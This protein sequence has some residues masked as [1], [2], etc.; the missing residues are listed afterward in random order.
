MEYGLVFT[1]YSTIFLVMLIITF[2]S[3]RNNKTIRVKLYTLAMICAFLF[4]LFELLTIY[5][6]KYITPSDFIAMF[7]W[8][9]RITFVIAFFYVYFSYCVML[10]SKKEYSSVKETIFKT[11]ALQIGLVVTFIAFLLAVVILKSEP[12]VLK[13]FTYIGGIIGKVLFTIAFLL[14]AY[15]I[16][17]SILVFKE[18]KYYLK[19]FIIISFIVLSLMLLQISQPTISYTPTIVI[20][21]V[22]IIYFN[23]ENPDIE[24]SENI[25]EL[26]SSVENLGISKI[27]FLFNISYDLVHPANTI[28]SLSET[29]SHK[30]EFN[31]E[32]ILK[33]LNNI[34]YEGALML[35]SVNN[36][37]DV[38]MSNEE[39]HNNEYKLNDLIEK[40]Q[41]DIKIKIDKKPIKFSIQ[42][43]DIVSASLIGD[44]DKVEKILF[45]VLNNAV[46]YTE[47][48]N[49][50]F[51]VS[52]TNDKDIQNVKFEISDTGIG[53]KDEIKETIFN[54][55]ISTDNKNLSIGL[56]LTK[57]LVDELGGTI[58]FNSTYKVGTT[59]YITI[60]QKVS[61]NKTY[62]HEQNENEHRNIEG[63]IDCSNYKLLVV[64]DDMLDIKVTQRLLE[65][66]NFQITTINSPLEC[67]DRIK[68]DEKYDMLL[69]DHKM[70]EMDGIEL[71]KILRD[72]QATKEVKYVMLT[73]NAVAGMKE[74]CI[75]E[76]FDEYIS[77]PINLKELDKIIKKYF[78]K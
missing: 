58:T 73:A 78:K 7:N 25:R 60:P 6:K 20:I 31:K 54:D 77:K 27:D 17:S 33:D 47:V 36:I 69:I 15:T 55:S 21:I 65:K 35:D 74:Y 2:T 37:V 61:G 18:K 23:I 70:P 52:A 13:D 75:K 71:M 3:K 26:K 24:L 59:F 67:I 64:D 68:A 29:L 30:Q 8:K 12:I 39:V 10:F 50:K 11:K 43:D 72:L 9:V 49:I 32:E 48:G 28:L 1:M 40:I 63:I 34:K 66:Y 16:V 38:S 19:T 56:M 5:V 57:K 4:G 53:I 14:C 76:G 44:Y 41:T 22:F 42:T 45:N 51:K 46:K 62:Q